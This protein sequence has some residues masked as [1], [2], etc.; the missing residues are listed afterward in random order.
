[1]QRTLLRKVLDLGAFL[2]ENQASHLSPSDT[3]LNSIGIANTEITSSK[4]GRIKL[5]GCWWDAISNS[6]ETI[7]AGKEVRVTGRQH[8]THTLLVEQAS[9]KLP[10]HVYQNMPMALTLT[11]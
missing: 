5:Y 3:Y 6:H 7:Q 10:Q 1:M 8:H 2:T 11:Q 4:R 9:I